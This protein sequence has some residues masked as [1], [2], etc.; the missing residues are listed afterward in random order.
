VVVGALAGLAGAV[1]EV[2]DGIVDADR[3]REFA[4]I[5]AIIGIPDG[6]EL[7]EGVDQF[8]AEHFGQERCP[9]LAV[10]VLAGE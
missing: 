8:G 5:H 7:A 6:F 3:I 10:A 9:R 1:A 4:G 2:L